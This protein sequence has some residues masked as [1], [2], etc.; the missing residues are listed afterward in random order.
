MLV[1]EFYEQNN[2]LRASPGYFLRKAYHV[3]RCKTCN[4]STIN[5]FMRRI[6]NKEILCDKGP[7][8]SHI[9]THSSLSLENYHTDYIL[10][11]KRSPLDWMDKAIHNNVIHTCQI[12]HKNVAWSREDLT[13]HLNGHDY[14]SEKYK[15]EFMA[16]Y[17]FNSEATMHMTDD[18]N[19]SDKNIF[20]CKVEGCNDKLTSRVRLVLHIQKVRTD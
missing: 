18:N 10:T 14:T 4:P 8:Q 13:A 1:S 16:V 9:R 5:N 11:N 15:V 2:L 6:C 19:W 3:C 20:E 17:R 7:L 12:C